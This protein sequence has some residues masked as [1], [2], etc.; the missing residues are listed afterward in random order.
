MRLPTKPVNEFISRESPEDDAHEGS[1][2]WDA[3]T[4]PEYWAIDE[5]C[6]GKLREGAAPVPF[7][8]GRDSAR[9]TQ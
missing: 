7:V 1:I 4:Q 2:D 3:L 6:L 9:V 8:K 5:H